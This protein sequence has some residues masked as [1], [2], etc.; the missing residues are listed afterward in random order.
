MAIFTDEQLKDMWERATETAVR[1]AAERFPEGRARQAAA[2]RIRDEE[3]GQ[4]IGR[5]INGGVS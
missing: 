1:L 2:E 4:M 3:Y 5:R